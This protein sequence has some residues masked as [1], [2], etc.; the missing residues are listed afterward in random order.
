MDAEPV[1]PD[2]FLILRSKSSPLVF[3][4]VRP[5]PQ[6]PAW[7]HPWNAPL[8]DTIPLCAA[9]VRCGGDTAA[10]VLPKEREAHWTGPTT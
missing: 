7:R 5:Y 8:A 2:A 9:S 1:T 4:T 10:R 6:D 3:Q